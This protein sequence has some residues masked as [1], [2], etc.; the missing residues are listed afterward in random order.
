[1]QQ[2]QVP[3]YINIEDRIIGPLTLKQF[4]YLVGGAAVL[5][6]AWFLL[7]PFLFVLI[8]I[9]AALLSTA[10]AFLKIN[11]RPFSVIL[12]NG[13]NFYL[14]PRLYIWKRAPPKKRPPATKPGEPTETQLKT[15]SLTESK[16]SDLS[17]SLDIKEKINR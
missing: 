4:L 12:I 13:I 11:G 7:H 10:L 5:V 2:F 16:I 6:I 17:W 15:P 8:A 1:M 3:Q 14:K 9:P